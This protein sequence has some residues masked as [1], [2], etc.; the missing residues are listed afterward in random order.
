MLEAPPGG[1]VNMVIPHM[2]LTR[3]CSRRNFPGPEEGQGHFVA[4]LMKGLCFALCTN[5]FHD[6]G[7]TERTTSTRNRGQ[8]EGRASE[9][10]EV[11]CLTVHSQ[12][13]PSSRTESSASLQC[14]NRSPGGRVASRT[15]LGATINWSKPS[16]RGRHAD[17]TGGE[18]GAAVWVGNSEISSSES[19]PRPTDPSLLDSVHYRIAVCG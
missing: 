8:G 12:M 7:G 18:R 13:L 15:V 16:G 9:T 1:H 6:R 19:V 10:A 14:A 17:G 11:A 3:E 2:T 5:S 4:R